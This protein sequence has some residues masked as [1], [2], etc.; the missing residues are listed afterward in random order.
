MIWLAIAAALAVGFALGR[1][2]LDRIVS[3][4]EDWTTP[5]WRRWRFWLAVPVAVAANAALWVVHPCRTLANVRS[6]RASERLLPAPEY[7]P[8]W[9]TRRQGETR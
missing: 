7:D 9:S 3:W 2:R 4:A 5:G 6:W 1:D 8:E